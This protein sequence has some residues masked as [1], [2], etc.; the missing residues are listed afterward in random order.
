MSDISKALY[1]LKGDIQI[2]KIHNTNPKFSVVDLTSGKYTELDLVCRLH[3][4]IEFLCAAYEANQ[5]KELPFITMF[6]RVLDNDGK[7]RVTVKDSKYN[8]R[9]GVVYFDKNKWSAMPLF[10]LC[11]DRHYNVEASM[12]RQTQIQEQ[13]NDLPKYIN[14]SDFDYIVRCVASGKL[15]KLEE[16]SGE[17][18]RDV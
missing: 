18:L 2:L 1:E 10:D 11:G 13:L 16:L 3:K 4:N 14:E 9:Y 17:G 7:Q 15:P 8:G 12:N 6:E 5:L